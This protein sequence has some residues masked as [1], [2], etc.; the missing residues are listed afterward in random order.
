MDMVKV[1]I[2]KPQ[3]LSLLFFL[4]Q[5]MRFMLVYVYVHSHINMKKKFIKK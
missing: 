4:K 5:R 1:K 3:T 2:I